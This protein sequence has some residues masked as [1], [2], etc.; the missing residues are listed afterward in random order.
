MDAKKL[1][2]ERFT[3]YAASYTAGWS[4][5]GGPDLARLVKLVGDK[6]RWEA[7]DI[8]TGAGHTALAVAPRVARVVATDVTEAMLAA[9]RDF[10]GSQGVRNVDFEPADAEELP[11]LAASFDLVTCRIAAHHFPHPE[12]FVSEV[13]RVLRP[14]GLFLLQD[15]VVPDGAAATYITDFERRRDPSHQRGLSEKEWESLLLAASLVI[16]TTDRF[17]KQVVLEK[18]VSA[19]G[20]T[21]EDLVD[22]RSRISQAPAAVREWMCPSDTDSPQAAFI[23][24]HCLFGA[25]KPGK[26]AL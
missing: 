2:Q 13:A 5:A 20:G 24:H 10:L 8:A 17:E 3:K 16:E 15:L 21:S 7:L 18:W 6:P 25:R 11:F 14:G 22:L 23:I 9:A 12:R 4:H 26:S 19:Q 1:S